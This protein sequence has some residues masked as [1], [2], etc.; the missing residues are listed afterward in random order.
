MR[1]RGTAIYSVIILGGS[2][3]KLGVLATILVSDYSL[4]NSTVSLLARDSLSLVQTVDR[5][6]QEKRREQSVTSV[7]M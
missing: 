4:Y 6:E 5:E 3:S 7:K 2:S 1:Q